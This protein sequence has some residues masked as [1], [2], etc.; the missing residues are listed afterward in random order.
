MKKKSTHP[1]VWCQRIC[2]SVC[3]SVANFDPNY[4]RTGKIEPKLAP[5]AGGM[6]FATQI[7]PLPNFLNNLL[8]ILM[9]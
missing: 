3:L 2:Q 9:I 6:K 1:R 8:D 5:L 4:L 7:S